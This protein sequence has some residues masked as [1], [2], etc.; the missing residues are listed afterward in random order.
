[1]KKLYTVYRGSMYYPEC[2]N[3]IVGFYYDKDEAIKVAS[4]PHSIRID[5]HTVLETDLET[6]EFKTIFGTDWSDGN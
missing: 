3:D 2:S 5:W 1:M 4:K 6:L